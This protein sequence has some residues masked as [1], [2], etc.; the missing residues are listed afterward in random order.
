M[1]RKDSG[2][3]LVV[4]APEGDVDRAQVTLENQVFWREKSNERTLTLCWEAAWEADFV[5]SHKLPGVGA[6]RTRKHP[7]QLIQRKNTE[8]QVTSHKSSWPTHRFNQ[9]LSWVL[10]ASLPP[11]HSL[12]RVNTDGNLQAQTFLSFIRR[13]RACANSDSNKIKLSTMC[14][15]KQQHL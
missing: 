2:W 10:A 12:P 8:T 3:H 13:N 9:S 1:G 11:T 6:G 5:Q 7:K 15:Y 4:S 14:C